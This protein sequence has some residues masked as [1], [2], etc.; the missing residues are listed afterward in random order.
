MEIVKADGVVLDDEVQTVHDLL[1][2]RFRFGSETLPEISTWV[3]SYRE[4]SAPPGSVG[5]ALRALPRELRELVIQSAVE[6]AWC[7]GHLHP[8]EQSAIRSL[9]VELDLDRMTVEGIL[10]PSTT[11]EEF[12]PFKA[13]GLPRHVD[14]ETIRAKVMRLRDQFKSSAVRREAEQTEAGP[15]ADQPIL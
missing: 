15:P 13:L 11:Q 5:R 14:S 12:D 1:E 2:S 6:L 3:D 9:G 8:N 10:A 4:R 7:D